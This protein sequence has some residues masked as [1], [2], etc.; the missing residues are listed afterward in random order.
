[1]EKI[2]KFQTSSGGFEKMGDVLRETEEVNNPNLEGEARRIMDSQKIIYVNDDLFDNN[3]H[4]RGKIEHFL[5]FIKKEK[6][7]VKSDYDELK[8]IEDALRNERKLNVENLCFEI[9][10]E[11]EFIQRFYEAKRESI[12]EFKILRSVGILSYQKTKR[13]IYNKQ[14]C[15]SLITKL[16]FQG[17]TVDC[18]ASILQ[19]NFL[20]NTDCWFGLG[21]YFT[22]QLDY[23]TFYSGSKQSF[24]DIPKLGQVFP[25]IASE[26]Y[27][28]PRKFKRI[29]DMSYKIILDRKRIHERDKVVE[30]NRDKAI[31]KDG[32]YYAEV[33]PIGVRS[34]PN[35]VKN[36]ERI[37]WERIC[38]YIQ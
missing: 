7:N 12:F 13:Y 1:M 23:A 6:M 26:V 19:D 37:C 3:K 22:D 24:N 14:K 34:I 29:N 2:R 16:L 28:N 17:T 20:I 5:R 4:V 32:I 36:R 18:I 9:K 21:I 31:I 11:Q 30:E 38:N 25:V 35:G 15:D 8:V 33:E 10:K 27:Y